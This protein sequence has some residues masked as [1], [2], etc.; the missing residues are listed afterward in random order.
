MS[1][2]GLKYLDPPI[3]F[4]MEVNFG[5][6][7]EG[8]GD[9]VNN[10]NKDKLN[11]IEDYEIFN[12]NLIDKNTSVSMNKT[13]NNYSDDLKINK[14]QND[15]LTQPN[16]N[17]N[18]FINKTFESKNLEISDNTKSIL[19]NLITRQISTKN[20]VQGE[21]DMEDLDDNGSK[22]GD[23]YSTIYYG[24]EGRGGNSIGYGLK[25]RNLQYQGK[26]VPKCN[27]S[28]TVVVRI[29][30]NKNGDVVSA[31]PGVKGTTNNH[32]CLMKPAKQTAL[33]HKWFPDKNAPERQI[34]FVLIQFKIVE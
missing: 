24:Q 17:N 1:F 14:N 33:M 34:G 30:V 3:E 2:V 25:G 31:K 9:E 26:E 20:Q 16:E 8:F 13:I 15:S 10:T 6:S 29:V 23:L 21:G 7:S 18:N 22:K 4:G 19:S 27:E 5:F 11:P 32:P 28:G 12:R